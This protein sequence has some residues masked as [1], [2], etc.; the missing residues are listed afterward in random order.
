MGGGKNTHTH[1]LTLLIPGPDHG[2]FENKQ[3]KRFRDRVTVFLYSG[4]TR[5]ICGKFKQPTH[6]AEV[7]LSKKIME[8]ISE[9]PSNF[10]R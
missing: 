3:G 1:T 5:G 9:L 6:R 8:R 4:E 10:E 7:K 2:T